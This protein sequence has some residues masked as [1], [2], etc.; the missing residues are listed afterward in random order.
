MSLTVSLAAAI[1]SAALL[2]APLAPVRAH[3]TSAAA[4][5]TDA[6]LLAAGDI[7]SCSSSGD[8]T[9]AALLGALTGTIVTLG[10]NAYPSG[11]PTEFTNCFGPRG[12][13]AGRTAAR[14]GT[15]GCGRG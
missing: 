15:A 12:A 10:D 11:S 13:A 6:V 9:T 4:T 2:F 14:R 1:C 8:S 3:R 5:S 7:A